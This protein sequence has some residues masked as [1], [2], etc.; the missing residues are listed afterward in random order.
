M[1]VPAGLACRGAASGTVFAVLDYL[2]KWRLR[3]VK[4]PPHKEETESGHRESRLARTPELS[5]LLNTRPL[6]KAKP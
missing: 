5:C 1:L 3:G 2:G 4:R 6:G